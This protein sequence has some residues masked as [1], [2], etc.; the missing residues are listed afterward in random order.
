MQEG[1][2]DACGMGLFRRFQSVLP[3]TGVYTF[4]K[5]TVGDFMVYTLYLSKGYYYF[6]KSHNYNAITSP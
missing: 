1:E 5:W 2:K 4:Q 3:L 6:L